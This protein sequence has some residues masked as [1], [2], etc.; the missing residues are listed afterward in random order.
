[1]RALLLGV[2]GA[3][4][5]GGL[6]GSFGKGDDGVAV[7]PSVRGQLLPTELAALPAAVERML[8]DVPAPAG[9]VEAVDQ[10]HGSPSVGG[11]PMLT[12]RA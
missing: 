5:R 3:G 10:L 1:M 6:L 12:R 2:L 7:L 8:E 4:E 9:G 11:H